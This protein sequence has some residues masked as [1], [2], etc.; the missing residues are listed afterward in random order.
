MQRRLSEMAFKGSP[1]QKSLE[2]KTLQLPGMLL[3]A[4]LTLGLRIFMQ[5]VNVE[6]MRKAVETHL[7][8]TQKSRLCNLKSQARLRF[9]IRSNPV[10]G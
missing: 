5:N 6:S 8:S 9:P 4:K 7:Q 3:Q 2:L 10:G 1:T